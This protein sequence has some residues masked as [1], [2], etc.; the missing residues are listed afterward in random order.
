[1]RTIELANAILRQGGYTRAAAVSLAWRI[2]NRYPELTMS[3]R[4]EPGKIRAIMTTD[5]AGIRRAY[6]R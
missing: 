6:K 4:A 1:M 5:A 2:L 3:L